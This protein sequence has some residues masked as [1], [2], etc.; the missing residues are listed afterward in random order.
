MKINDLSKSIIGAAIEVHR[1][2][3]PGLLESVYEECMAKELTI[4]K[5]PFERQRTLPLRYKGTRLAC[6]LRLDFLVSESI[7][8]ELRAVEQL[9][10]AHEAQVLSYLKLGGWNLELLINFCVPALKDG[11]RRLINGR[12]IK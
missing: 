5:I 6:G 3:G 7:V 12:L 2:V 8:M 4:R 9:L 11:I 1:T 10:P